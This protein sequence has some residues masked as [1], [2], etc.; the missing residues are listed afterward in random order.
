MA[1]EERWDLAEYALSFTSERSAAPQ[2]A[3]ARCYS[4]PIGPCQFLLPEGQAAELISQPVFTPL[5]NAP[6]HC[7]GLANVRGN[8]VPLYALHGFIA[9]AQKPTREQVRYALLIGDTVDGVLLAI[10]AKPQAIARDL[11]V[12]TSH[13]DP[14]LVES[15]QQCLLQSY[16]FDHRDWWTLDCGRLTQFLLSAGAE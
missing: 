16:S 1:P 13:P 15:V 9:G 7:L 8:I 12:Q 11:L 2:A 14:K 5:P 4:F 6:D 3:Q 10:D